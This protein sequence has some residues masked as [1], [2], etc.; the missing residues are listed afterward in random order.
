MP[1]CSGMA[2]RGDSHAVQSPR[3][4]SDGFLYKEVGTLQAFFSNNS[5]DFNIKA[6]GLIKHDIAIATLPEKY[7][8]CDSPVLVAAYDR[9]YMENVELRVINFQ[10]VEASSTG[11][12]KLQYPATCIEW[13]V[14]ADGIEY[15]E[16]SDFE[17]TK[18]GFVKWLTQKR[19]GYNDKTR[20]GTVYSVRYRYT[21]YFI[22]SR[23][24]H[25]IRLSSI[26][27]PNTFDRKVERM[28]YQVA[29]IR[30]HVLADVNNDNSGIMDSRFQAAPPVG[31]NTGPD[32]SNGSGGML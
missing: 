21:P 3:K 27:D 10:Y 25:E 12:D 26:T 19:P 11:I 9:F 24:L 23:I 30:E 14:D 20:R 32:E 22:V 17:I 15:Q 29:L 31:G 28:P 7:D 18:E 4:S 16:G 6:E 1:D 13:L 2:S 8:N 5:S